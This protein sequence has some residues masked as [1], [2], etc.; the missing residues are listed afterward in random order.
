[1]DPL[2]AE[3]SDLLHSAGAPAAAVT[4]LNQALAD[5]R[6]TSRSTSAGFAADNRKA[7][8]IYRA[9]A[10]LLRLWPPGSKSDARQADAAHAVKASLRRIRNEFARRYVDLICRRLSRDYTRFLRI[11]ELAYEAAAVS[12]GLCPSRE[13][14]AVESQLRLADKEGVEIAQGDFLSHVFNHKPSGD[15]LLYSM[16]RPLPESLELLGKFHTDGR[17]DLGPAQVA[18]S[19]VLGA[20]YLNNTRYL[21]AE[22]ETTL[23]PLEIA[24][25]LALLDSEIQVGLLRGNAVSHSRYAGRRIF[26]AGLN[27]THLYEGRIP[28]LFY[29][30]RDLGFTNKIYRGLACD[31]GVS[32]EPEST[33]EKPWIA[34]VDGFAIGGGCQLLLVA[35]HVIAETGAYFNLPARKEGIIPGI[36][37][38]RLARFV[39][40]RVAQQAILFDKT[41]PVDSDEARTIINEVVPADQM[42]AAI[43]RA[44]RNATGSGLVSFGANRKAIRLGREPRDL[45]RQYLALYC[46]EQADCHFSP[47]LVA[48][49]E[50]HWKA[51]KTAATS[52]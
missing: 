44:V 51:R 36:A 27:L 43:E 47:A 21:N 30:T 19:G 16:L 9:G 39:G 50:R 1:M 25:D 13:E 20:V 37:P 2:S 24:T 15:Y 45:L 7:Q 42:D 18:R 10:D 52:D 17:L 26:S 41:F 5:L 12:P 29:L 31:G 35:D 49:L 34:A 14:V 8:S 33:R 6:L 22:D 40:E 48:N 46:R 32:D 11:E 4:R 3:Q 23:R 38:L 28:F